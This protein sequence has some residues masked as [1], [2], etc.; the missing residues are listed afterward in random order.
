MERGGVA[1][2]LDLCGTS[3]D[4]STGNTT[5][6]APDLARDKYGPILDNLKQQLGRR[7]NVKMEALAY[8][9]YISIEHYLSSLPL[10]L[11]YCLFVP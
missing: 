7:S 9:Y 1:Y 10:Q 2:T 11:I 3:K 8:N 6:K 4:Q 5:Q